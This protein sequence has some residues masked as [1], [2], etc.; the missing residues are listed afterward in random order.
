[1][2]ESLVTFK[3]AKLAKEKG[4]N[5]ISNILYFYTK[6]KSKMFGIDEKGRYYPIKNTPKKLYKIGEHATLNIENVIESPTQSLLQKWLREEKNIIVY[7]T[8]VLYPS[9]SWKYNILHRENDKLLYAIILGGSQ[10][11]SFE[12]S[13]EEGLEKALNLLPS[14]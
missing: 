10:N 11:L 5:N 2:K 8:F 9:F 13:L 3:T 14:I 1:M 6:P 12:E 4:F 7:Q